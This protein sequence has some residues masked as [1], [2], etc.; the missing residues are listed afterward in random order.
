MLQHSSL[1]RCAQ[2]EATH[3]PHLPTALL[4]KHA[5]GNTHSTIGNPCRL[6][7]A[8]MLL[9]KAMH[10]T[11]RYY[12]TT[13]RSTAQ[14]SWQHQ[15]TTRATTHTHIQL[16]VL[17]VLPHT[18]LACCRFEACCTKHGL[19]RTRH[20]STQTIEVSWLV[21]SKQLTCLHALCATTAPTVSATD[22]HLLCCKV[23]ACMHAGN[24]MR[25][26][27]LVQV[28]ALLPSAQSTAQ[29]LH[30]TPAPG[31]GCR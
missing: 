24:S 17:P 20:N 28:P 30:Y 3:A 15:S 2:T 8:H 18:Q 27:W 6:T 23:R 13:Q 25:G 12:P 26:K 9:F 19:C 7:F 22:R 16:Q 5:A 14:P 4:A 21:S 11:A 29:P 31:S 10:C 1:Q